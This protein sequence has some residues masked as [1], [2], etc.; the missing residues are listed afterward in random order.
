MTGGKRSGVTRRV[1]ARPL[2]SRRVC[3]RSSAACH[4]YPVVAARS[5]VIACTRMSRERLGDAQARRGRSGALIAPPPAGGR[6]RQRMPPRRDP[7]HDGVLIM[8]DRLRARRSSARLT[9]GMSPAS[10]TTTGVRRPAA[11]NR[12]RP[13]A[14]RVS[15]TSGTCVHATLACA[16]PTARPVEHPIGCPAPSDVPSSCRSRIVCWPTHQRS[17][18]AARM[19]DRC[20]RA[21]RPARPP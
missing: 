17:A 16:H 2:D 1:V 6:P 10:T 21:R 19:P 14:P 11:P 5:L 12:C 18:C 9:N 7:R 15:T 4:P 20:A 8:L 3:S 13:A